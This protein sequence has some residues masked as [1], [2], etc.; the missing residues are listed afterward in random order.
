MRVERVD[1][2]GCKLIRNESG[3]HMVS[4]SMHEAAPDLLEALKQCVKSSQR[5]EP[6][7]PNAI[8]AAHIAIA[9]AEGR[10]K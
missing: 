3:L 7:N 4:C 1:D 5:G 10:E 8:N 2:C 9:K 6:W